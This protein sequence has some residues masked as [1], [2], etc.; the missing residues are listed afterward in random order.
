M[1][2][3][4][5]LHLLGSPHI[6]LKSQTVKNKDRI[7]QHQATAELVLVGVLWSQQSDGSALGGAAGSQEVQRLGEGSSQEGGRD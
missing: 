6:Q 2:P 5:L 1:G 7:R 4:Q 3:R